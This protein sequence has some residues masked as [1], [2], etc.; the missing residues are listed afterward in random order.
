[1]VQ[2]HSPRPFF[3]FLPPHKHDCEFLRASVHSSW[4]REELQ[5]PRPFETHEGPGTRKNKT[6]HSALTYR[7]GIIQL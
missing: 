2:I 6:S 1:M 5:K 7:S 4:D 3:T